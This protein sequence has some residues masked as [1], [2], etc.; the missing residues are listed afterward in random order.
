MKGLRFFGEGGA[1]PMAG[2]IVLS[3]EIG[4]EDLTAEG[5]LGTEVEE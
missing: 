3:G 1:G 4:F 5:A 2:P